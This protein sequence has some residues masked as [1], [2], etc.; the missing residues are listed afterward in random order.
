[1]K[2]DGYEKAVAL[3][4]QWLFATLSEKERRRSAGIEAAKLGHG[5]LEYISGLFGIDPKTI[6]R[7][8]MELAPTDDAAPSRVRKNGGGCKTALER[9]P[10]LDENFRQILAE[11]TAGEPMREGVLWTHLSR[12]A[13]RRRLAERGTPASRHTVRKL[14]KKHGLGQRKVRKKKT[15]GAHPDCD[16]QFQ[17]IA[18]IKA[19]DLAA[20]DPVI[21]L[22][23]Q[24]KELIGHVARDGHTYTQA[25]VDVLDHEFPSAG[26]GQLIPHGMYDLARNEGYL[27]LNTSHDTSEFCGDSIAR[28]WERH[29]RQHSPNARR[30]LLLCDGGG[31]H[32]ANHHRFKEDLQALADR[33][34]LELRVAHD[35]PDCA[36][37]NPIEHRLFPHITRACQGVVFHSIDIAKPLMEKAKTAKGLTV[38]VDILTGCYATGR[39]CAANFLETMRI[40]FDEHLPRWNY[41]AIPQLS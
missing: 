4:M 8:L 22:D 12:R 2:L 7:G 34:G 31:S 38:T 1:M 39:Q 15:L 19:E 32:A 14:M 13:S 27:H 17:N 5:G 36:K 11:F 16:A 3:K 41:R 10:P 6:R 26:A 40:V 24:K 20:G 21:S 28:W 18:K 37:H 9:R 30:R 29:G 35:P 23:T 25:P 33:L